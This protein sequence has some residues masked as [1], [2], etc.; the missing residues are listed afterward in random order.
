MNTSRLVSIIIPAYKSDY[1]EATLASAMRQNHDDIEIVICDDCPTG[2]IAAI[3]EK[4]RE[5]SRWPIRY[6]RNEEQLGEAQNVVRCIAEAKGAYIKFLYDDDIIVPDCVRLLLDT[7]E[8]NPHVSLATSRR[9]M[10]DENSDF[11]PENAVTQFPFA[12]SMILNGK[13]LVSFLGEHPYNFIGEP[14]SVMCRRADV[15]A[16]GADLM[17]L[18]GEFINWL[19]DVTVY[20]K[21][22]RNGNLAMLDRPLSYFRV[23]TQQYSQQARDNPGI[24]TKWHQRYRRLT[25]ELGWVRDSENND[26]VSVAPL[27]DPENFKNFYLLSHFIG[28]PERL[29]S[30]NVNKWLSKRIPSTTQRTLIDA[31]LKAN[32]AGPSFLIILSDLE[33]QSSKVLASL[34]SLTSS[35]S[36]PLQLNIVV[37]SAYNDLPANNFGERLQWVESTFESRS[38]TLNSLVEQHTSEWVMLADAGT[39]FTASGLLCAAIELIGA[40]N[41]RAVYADEIHREEDNQQGLVFR[42]DFNLD[43]LLSFPL[44]MSRHWLF[45]RTEVINAGG[46]DAAFPEALEFD[47]ILRL[48]ENGGLRNIGHISEP[49]LISSAP[50][51]SPNDDEIKALKCHV[52]ARGYD[53]SEI[54]QTLPRRYHIKYG[55]AERPLVS[56]LIPTKDHLNILRR[57]VESVLE[58]TVYQN[59]EILIIDNNSET[60]ETQDWLTGV[61]ALDSDKIRVLRYPYSFNYSAINNMAAKQARGEYLVLMNDDTAVLQGDWLEELLNHALR[62]EVGIVGAKLLYPNG[63]IQHAGVVLGMNGPAKHLFLAE[64]LSVKSYMQR[65]EV[66][67]NYSVVT[68][69]CL[70]IRKSIY[71]EVG[72]LDEETFKVSYNDVDLCLKVGAAGHLIV[73]TP[74]VTLLHESSVSQIDLGVA[75]G[76]ANIKRFRDEQEGIYA[77][78]LPILANDPA[79]NRNFSLG[80]SDFAL[81]FNNDLTWRPLSWRPLPVV[82]AQPSVPWGSANYRLIKPFDTLRNNLK[83]D[84]A[85]CPTSL[86]IF[87]LQ[88]FNPDSIVLQRRLHEDGLEAMR[89]INAYSKVFK[90]YE[91]DE[92]PAPLNNVNGTVASITLD[93]L[94]KALSLVDRVVVPSLSLAD[95]LSNM[96]TDIRVVENR[97]PLDWW[98]ALSSQRLQSKKPR[99][100]WAGDADQLDNLQLIIDVVKLLA[101]EVEWVFMG[102]CPIELRPYIHEFRT[103]PELELFPAALASLN[104]DLALAPAKQNLLNESRGNLA[105]LT[106]GACGFPVVCSDLQCFQGDLNVTR[107]KNSTADWIEAIRA[108]INDKDFS[109]RMGDTLRGQVY[110]NW[111]LEGHHLDL[112]LSAWLP[113]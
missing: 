25:R 7:L 58:K 88:R 13:E 109:A 46:F 93:S 44:A 65:L 3:V 86:S 33:N 66:D 32:D 27:S 63:T 83:L 36:I 21:L 79:Y 17:S 12:Q 42:P 60:P 111:M 74:H 19:G 87:E 102:A 9:R 6:F 108:H 8:N 110:D 71:D 77:K 82:I 49:L 113:D 112:W 61:D 18:N 4:N 85:I 89:L 5:A 104:L 28:V 64:P 43:Y 38:Y 52:L 45:R 72:G 84:G 40:S 34:Q 106:Y 56:I 98:Q 105:L 2:A 99:V 94:R 59:Y 39:E 73:W 76:K 11:L 47:L 20:L 91:L 100:G 55:H 54:L 81:E 78:W 1:F 50:T 95:A 92:Y 10:I 67:Q 22:L 16:F 29:A 48:I 24:A 96:H 26:H 14:S 75:V 31:Y 62:P 57:C 103:A 23:S 70:M 51:F 107:V 30:N 41:F 90:V 37:L 68:A 80:G 101:D 15:L 97:L 69:A 35:N 53:N